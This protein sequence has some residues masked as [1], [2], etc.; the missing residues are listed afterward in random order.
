MANY[1][2]N[3]L[4]VRGK[5]EDLLALQSQA[6]EPSMGGYGDNHSS[7]W[8]KN[9]GEDVLAYRGSSRRSPPVEDA[10]EL[11]RRIPDGLVEL[12]FVDEGFCYNG[13][14]AFKNGD[15]MMEGE[16]TDAECAALRQARESLGE[17]ADE[18]FD[19]FKWAT[20]RHDALFKSNR[21][22]LGWRAPDPLGKDSYFGKMMRAMVEDDPS[23]ADWAQVAGIDAGARERLA[24]LFD[25]PSGL[26]RYHD[27]MDL[28]PSLEFKNTPFGS[29]SGL[30]M[31]AKLW[32]SGSFVGKA[33]ETIWALLSNVAEAI[34]KPSSRDDF[35]L[36][37]SIE[38]RMGL[39]MGAGR[40]AEL[41]YGDAADAAALESGNMGLGCRMLFGEHGH[42]G[43]REAGPLLAAKAFVD[44]SASRGRLGWIDA[45]YSHLAASSKASDE[46]IER[47]MQERESSGWMS[48]QKTIDEV[49]EPALPAL[50][51]QTIDQ[52]LH[53][54]V[55]GRAARALLERE[56]LTR[57]SKIG[58]DAKV[59]FKTL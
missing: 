13:C 47:L 32:E 21:S 25:A 50:S 42:W 40:S 41:F 15:L 56:V 4:I 38:A 35:E 54:K 8:E 23:C 29:V 9:D 44:Q 33:P 48:S 59:K 55:A 30:R 11:S 22:A 58:S 45:A 34:V 37:K 26:I 39:L 24:I 2:Y 19:E 14:M 20:D 51:T 57:S 1:S 49:L 31:F 16:L 12:S 17:N 53:S 5:V 43:Y 18:G 7:Q 46:E 3:W 27:E 52:L 6:Y 36:K 28:K 10:A